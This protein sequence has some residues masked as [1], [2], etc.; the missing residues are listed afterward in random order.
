MNSEPILIW[1]IKKMHLNMHIS[2]DYKLYRGPNLDQKSPIK[3]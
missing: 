2:G 3:K 1:P